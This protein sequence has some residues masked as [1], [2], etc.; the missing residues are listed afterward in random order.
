MILLELEGSAWASQH[1]QRNILWFHS[2]ES[3]SRIE[4]N[5]EVDAT[6]ILFYFLSVSGW[7][8]AFWWHRKMEAMGK[9]N[10]S[11]NSFHFRNDEISTSLVKHLWILTLLVLKSWQKFCVSVENRFLVEYPEQCIRH[12]VYSSFDSRSNR[13]YRTT[14]SWLMH[15]QIVC[16]R[17]GRFECF[18]IFD[19]RLNR[20]VNFSVIVVRL[21][22]IFGRTWCREFCQCLDDV[23]HCVTGCCFETNS[24]SFGTDHWRYIIC[25]WWRILLSSQ[26]FRFYAKF[27]GWRSFLIRIWHTLF[28]N[29]FGQIICI[30]C[31][32]LECF[33]IF[34]SG[35]DVCRFIIHTESCTFIRMI[36]G[37]TRTKCFPFGRLTFANGIAW[38]FLF[39]YVRID[40]TNG[41]RKGIISRSGHIFLRLFRW[42][43]SGSCFVIYSG[44]REI[45]FSIENFVEYRNSIAFTRNLE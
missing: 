26:T 43:H 21:R 40:T 37:W 41:R 9:F 14:V 19:S 29:D 45:G 33:Q 30:W 18:E 36:N 5:N 24:C 31:R 1:S 22:E 27:I 8:S 3:D 28:T 39:C 6:K 38:I 23:A 17:T 11:R 12:V 2:C 34:Q 32:C 7:K 13:I 10:W 35:A 44:Q 15:L 25:I 16:V 4:H 20:R 42:C